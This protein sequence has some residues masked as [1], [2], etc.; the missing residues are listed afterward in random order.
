MMYPIPPV[1]PVPLEHRKFFYIQTTRHTNYANHKSDYHHRYLQAAQHTNYAY[2][3]SD[4]QYLYL[5]TARRHTNYG[6]HSQHRSDCTSAYRLPDIQSSNPLAIQSNSYLVIS[7]DGSIK[8]VTDD[9]QDSLSDSQFLI[10][11]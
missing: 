4:C 7:N 10:L 11:N 6:I 1:H 3:K 9:L 5:Q 8:A 2:L